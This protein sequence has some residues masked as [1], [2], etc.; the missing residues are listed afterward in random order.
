MCCGTSTRTP[1]TA[2]PASAVAVVSWSITTASRSP[3]TA[4]ATT[5]GT[6]TA[7]ASTPVPAPSAPLAAPTPSAHPAAA[8]ARPL[9]PALATVEPASARRAAASGAFAAH[10]R[11]G[12]PALPSA[13]GPA[14][15]GDPVRCPTDRGR[16]QLD[17]LSRVPSIRPH[18]WQHVHDRRHRAGYGQ[19]GGGA[20]PPAH[21]HW[22]RGHLRPGGALPR[23]AR[24][25]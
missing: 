17:T 1:A 21:A 12:D 24:A 5:A 9:A 6:A 13:A 3:P 8:V 2:S 20:S 4:V 15:Y 16:A 23:F 11:T 22:L 10:P 25:V 7:F 19:L 18:R 14:V